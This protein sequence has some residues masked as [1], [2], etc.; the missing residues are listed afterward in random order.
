MNVQQS[1]QFVKITLYVLIFLVL[2]PA[3]VNWD[4][5]SLILHAE[6]SA[7]GSWCQTIVREVK[8]DVYGKRQ[9]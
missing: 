3:S 5:P 4:I 9:K 7:R 1:M 2:L 8:H 6:V